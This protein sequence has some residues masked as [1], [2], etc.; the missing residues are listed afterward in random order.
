MLQSELTRRQLELVTRVPGLEVED[1]IS[2]PELVVCGN[3]SVG[4]SSVLESITGIPL[5]LAGSTRFFIEIDICHA[6]CERIITASIQPHYTRDEATATNLRAYSRVLADYTE[7]PGVIEDVGA[8]LELKGYAD[9]DHSLYAYASDTLRIKVLGDTG[10]S[11]KVVDVPPVICR[12][13]E[14]ARYVKEVLKSHLENSSST[15]L[16][17]VPADRLVKTDYT[18]QLC[19]QYD[20]LGERTIG[21][22]TKPDLIPDEQA[23]VDLNRLLQNKGP[24]K[25]PLGLFVLQNDNPG[26]LSRRASTLGG[27]LNGLDGVLNG[28]DTAFAN[29]L[30]FHSAP[31]RTGAPALQAFLKARLEDQFTSELPKI[32]LALTQRLREIRQQYVELGAPRESVRDQRVYLSELSTN[33]TQFV[34]SAMKGMYWDIEFF[35]EAKEDASNNRLREQVQRLNREFL[36]YMLE[37][38]QTVRIS[39]PEQQQK[40]KPPPNLGPGNPSSQRYSMHMSGAA[41][42]SSGGS[43]GYGGRPHTSHL[44]PLGEPQMVSHKEFNDWMLAIYR[45]AKATSELRGNQTHE[46]L[47]EMFRAQSNRWRAIG[48]LHTKTAH[49][50]ATDFVNRVLDTVVKDATVRL[51]LQRIVAPALRQNLSAALEELGKVLNDDNVPPVT[52]E[53]YA[54][55]RERIA[56]VEGM[57]VTFKRAF[58]N[59]GQIKYDPSSEER[60]RAVAALQPEFKAEW[61]DRVVCAQFLPALFDYYK[62]RFF[63]AVHLFFLSYILT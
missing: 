26:D 34:H 54:A 44:A 49:K 7:L 35:S 45:K 22:I 5:R 33:F 32:S 4:K 15:I 47:P 29:N 38:S 8:L 27:A 25:L 53:W 63:A 51:E 14:D 39:G 13:D 28:L 2:V 41:S 60:A 36:N 18:F 6:T 62:V 48:E 24:G 58:Q 3:P 19:S 16:A 10:I 42:V 1:F 61:D 30:N 50:I 43:Q 55:E 11:V 12:T 59:M 21:V 40:K 56:K 20:P 52:C 46:I 9:T 17:V 57:K 31:E 23:A 37:K